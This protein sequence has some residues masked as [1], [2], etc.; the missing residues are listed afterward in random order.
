MTI[1]ATMVVEYVADTTGLG[2]ATTALE[3]LGIAAV[4]AT[5]L[6]VKM[7]GDFQQGITRLVTGAGDATDNMTMMG[8]GILATSVATGV[9]TNGTDGLNAAMYLIISSGQRGAQALDTLSVAAKGA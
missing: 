5:A 7:A 8:K 9:L 1:L 4:G 3:A 6:S 2:R